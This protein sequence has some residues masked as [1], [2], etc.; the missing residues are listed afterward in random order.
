MLVFK[1]GLRFD[2]ERTTHQ[3][4]VEYG[5]TVARNMY[6]QNVNGIDVGHCQQYRGENAAGIRDN[7]LNINNMAYRDTGSKF[8]QHPY[9]WKPM[10][11]AITAM[12]GQILLTLFV[13]Y[14]NTYIYMAVVKAKTKR[15]IERE[16][17][18]KCLM[19]KDYYGNFILLLP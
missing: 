7:M 10:Q 9:T 14:K 3:N 5:S 8:M 17:K 16:Y 13:K 15:D 12:L 19:K 2:S 6:Q 18:A 1:N 11:K 4:I